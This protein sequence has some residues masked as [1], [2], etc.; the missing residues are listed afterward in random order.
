LVIS[1]GIVFGVFVAGD[2]SGF[3]VAFAMRGND[4]EEAG[5]VSH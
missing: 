5:L 1:G 2:R 3:G 4:L